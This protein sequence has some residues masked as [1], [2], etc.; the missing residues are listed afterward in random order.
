MKKEYSKPEIFFEDFC[1]ST[2]ISVGCDRIVGNPSEGNCAVKGTGDVAIFT[3]E[4]TRICSFTPGSF[5]QPEDTWDGFC[6]HV[7]VETSDLFNS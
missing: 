6:Y 5:G 7:P 2:S 1:L 4:M 3:S